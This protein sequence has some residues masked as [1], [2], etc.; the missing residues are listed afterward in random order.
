[1]TWPIAPL[2]LEETV[3]AARRLWKAPRFGGVAV[4]TIAAA[5]APSLIFGLVSRAVL[6]PLPFAQSHELVHMWQRV[7]WRMATSYP[8]LRYLTEHS[9]TMDVAAYT[10]AVFFSDQNGSS[11]RL[12]ARAITPNYFEV[13]RVRSLLGRTF[14]QDENTRPFAHPVVILS[15]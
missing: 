7:P 5:T 2:L 10:S 4:L 12:D 9:R 14:R 11:L 1:M 6:P 8:K 15:E 3:L 13:F